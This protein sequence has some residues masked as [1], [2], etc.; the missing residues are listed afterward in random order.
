MRKLRKQE[1]ALIEGEWFDYTK[2]AKTFG[3]IAIGIG[4]VAGAGAAVY[5]ASTQAGIANQQLALAGSQNARQAQSFNQLQALIQNP[6][7]FFSSSVFTSAL[8]VGE[9]ATAHQGAAAFGPNSTN[10]A[11]ALQQYGQGFAANQL[12]SQE[13]LLAGMSGTQ[14]NPSGALGGASSAASSA[15]GSM[16][17]L[18]GL[19]AF[20]GS[21][22]GFGGGGVSSTSTGSGVGGGT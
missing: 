14:F 15:S 11:A 7:S 10:E 9:Q 17:G 12:L 22:G 16:A 6:S 13:Q 8:G 21:S 4:L 1:F 19:M 3:A 18:G 20:F 2:G 5:G